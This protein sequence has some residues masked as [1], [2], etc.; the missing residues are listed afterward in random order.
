MISLTMPTPAA[1][2]R[3]FVTERDRD[4]D[5]VTLGVR[6]VD[7]ER[8]AETVTEVDI[9]SLVLGILRIPNLLK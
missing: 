1:F 5:L 7:L 8:G 2:F 4:R 6:D 9:L 3:R